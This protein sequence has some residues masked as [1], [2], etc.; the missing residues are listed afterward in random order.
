MS[1]FQS[2]AACHLYQNPRYRYRRPV[3]LPPSLMYGGD[4]RTFWCAVN[5]SSGPPFDISVHVDVN[6]NG[7]KKEIK[8]EMAL[9]DVAASSLVLWKVYYYYYLLALPL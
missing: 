8:T 1:E 6:V 2:N 3:V 7:L 5:G 4:T 9:R